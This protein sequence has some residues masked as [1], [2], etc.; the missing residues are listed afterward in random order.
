LEE[1]YEDDWEDVSSNS[2]DDDDEGALEE[3]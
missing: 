3:D 1:L 2:A